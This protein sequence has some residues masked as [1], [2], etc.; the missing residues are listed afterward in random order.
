MNFLGHEI[1]HQESLIRHKSTFQTGSVPKQNVEAYHSAL[2]K[3][4][5]G[6]SVYGVK[7]PCQRGGG[8]GIVLLK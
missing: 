2:V 4:D 6:L 5:R 3:M 8:Q 1:I 7:Y